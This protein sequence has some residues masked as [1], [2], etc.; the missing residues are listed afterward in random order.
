MNKNSLKVL[1]IA[2]RNSNN[3][4][5]LQQFDL[6]GRTNQQFFFNKVKENLTI[7]VLFNKKCLEVE[8]SS[9]R[10]RANIVQVIIC[11]KN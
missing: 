5:P 9:L 8:K 6:G 3:S 10:N 11:I 7:K 4:T 1:D 2:D